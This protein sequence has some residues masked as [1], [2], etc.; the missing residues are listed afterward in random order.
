VAVASATVGA[1]ASMRRRCTVATGLTFDIAEKRWES[2]PSGGVSSLVAP[3]PIAES[4]FLS[5][6]TLSPD[7][8]R[9]GLELSASY[10]A[11][12]SAFLTGTSC[13]ATCTWSMSPPA[14]NPV[15]VQHLWLRDGEELVGKLAY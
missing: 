4:Q 15:D 6:V 3:K 9:L 8:H 12:R 11:L 13:S 5:V 1:A 7:R 10:M 14:S 2:L